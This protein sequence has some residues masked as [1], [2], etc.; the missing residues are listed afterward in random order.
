MS[1]NNLLLDTN[2]IL[3]YL[4]GDETLLPLMEEKNLFISVITEME[5]LSYAHFEEE[6]LK[7]IQRFLQFCTS[8]DLAEKV[9]NKA[10]VLRRSYSIKLP[11]A[12]IIASAIVMDFPFI[13]ADKDFQKVKEAK[14]ILYEG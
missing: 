5:L 12:I 14:L 2:I 13:S 10:I 7:Q 11:D 8:I 3:Y 6:E 1:G 9:K 4:G